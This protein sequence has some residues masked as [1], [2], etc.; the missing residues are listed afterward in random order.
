MTDR[1][2]ALKMARGLGY[3]FSGTL[4]DLADAILEAQAR[5]AERAARWLTPYKDIPDNRRVLRKRAS[6]LREQ[7]QK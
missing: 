2:E 4:N 1:E 5:E 3:M 6:R 7:K